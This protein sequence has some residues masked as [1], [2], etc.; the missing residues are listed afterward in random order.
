MVQTEE[1]F[2]K[3]TGFILAEGCNL[4]FTAKGQATLYSGR[5][6]PYPMKAGFSTRAMSS[7]L[8]LV[9]SRQACASSSPFG[10]DREYWKQSRS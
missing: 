5:F 8:L 9:L 10:A 3:F 6:V 4:E 7:L 2:L 1:V